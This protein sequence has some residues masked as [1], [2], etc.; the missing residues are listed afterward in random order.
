MPRKTKTGRSNST[1]VSS[2]SQPDIRLA[3][4]PTK[5][6]LE[7]SRYLKKRRYAREREEMDKSFPFTPQESNEEQWR[8]VAVARDAKRIRTAL[9]LDEPVFPLHCDLVRTITAMML[10]AGHQVSDAPLDTQYLCAI[11]RIYDW[12]LGRV[13]PSDEE[14]MR[15]SVLDFLREQVSR[16]LDAVDEFR[17]AT[18][19]GVE[20]PD[21]WFHSLRVIPK[22]A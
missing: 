17:K 9:E 2:K 3:P 11:Q 21:S 7:I 19:S 1:A 20:V 12:D 18:R 8:N 16:T 14:W 10:C 15:I 4:Q 13:I 6:E 22:V 5:R